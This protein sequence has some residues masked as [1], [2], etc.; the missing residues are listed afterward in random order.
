MNWT[1]HSGAKPVGGASCP[2]GTFKSWRAMPTLQMY[3]VERKGTAA[4]IIIAIHAFK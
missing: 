1:L 2:A 3:K 4:F